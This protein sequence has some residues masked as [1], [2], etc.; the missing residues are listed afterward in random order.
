M[1]APFNYTVQITGQTYSSL[2]AIS[3]TLLGGTPPYTVNWA[4]PNLGID[5]NILLNSSRENL[6]AGTYNIQVN[7]STLPT[8]GTFNIN[9]PISSGV[10]A[11]IL[12]VKNTTCG[13]NNGSVTGTS[14]S[15]YSSTNFYLYTLDNFLISTATTNTSNVVFN[16]LSAGTYYLIAQDLGGNT[17]ATPSFIISQSNSMDFG[18]YV[19]PN[20]SCG[21]N[22][23]G[24]ITVTGL[25]GS[26][27]FTYLW[28]TGQSGS[29]ITGLTSGTY[30]VAVTD[31]LGCTKT[32]EGTVTNI[33]QLGL[34]TIV[35][36][37]PTCFSS[38][39]SFTI[40]VTGGTAPYYFSASTGNISIQYGNSWTL[41][42]LSSGNYG[43]LVTDAALCSFLTNVTL[44]APQGIQQ[45]N[46]TST[47]SVCND[48]DG[49]I[50]VS[51]TGGTSPFTYSIVKPGGGTISVTNSQTSQVFKNLSSGTY[52]VFVTDSGGCTYNEEKTI[53]A[54]NKFVIN[55]QIT[56]TTCNQN[57]GSILITKT[58]GGTEPFT[59]L[60]DNI[61]VVSNT[62]LSAVTFQ[63]VI[64][65][66]HFV[67][68]KDASGCTQTKQIFVAQSVSLNFSLYK[69][70]CG[71]GSQGAITAFIS[72]GTPP[73]SYIWS[74]NVSGNPQSISAT[75][76]SAGTYNLKIID[77]DGCSLT[78]ETTITC[79]RTVSS[80]QTYIMGSEEF[81]SVS[82][83]KYGLLQMLNDGY[84]ELT[85]GNTG[86]ELISAIFNVS[87][88]V[89]PLG[90]SAS[91]VIYTGYTLT[92]VPSDNIYYDAVDSLLSGISGITDVQINPI[93]NQ[94]TITTTKN[95]TT[96][97]GQE[98]MVKLSIDY[99][100]MC[101][102]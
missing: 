71:T 80:Y 36:V 76:L 15:N 49:Q 98:V 39:G 6:Y 87:V 72:S 93:N 68:V 52:S 51:I 2:G 54:T 33:N 3:L 12:S 83:T 64:G 27:P 81:L 21:G 56:G 9:V 74:N 57:N 66:Q 91:S 85:S 29:T 42:G 96:L 90:Y 4:N 25:T 75:G 23:I 1:S 99:D 30:S 43:I 37:Q 26:P 35:P 38:N 84:T 8:N 34:G 18:L 59:Y 50:S 70:S 46:I 89:D 40:V 31:N 101:L 62:T 86:C 95:N 5:S 32:K 73:F 79:D 22:P 63:N 77:N 60:L 94:I 11:S 10:C 55:T 16:Q 65:G 88:E 48:T 7:D 41:S 78:R 58:S 47:N 44:V 67:S 45:V 19:V 17:G 13:S 92:D 100:I 24:K 61:P 69:T 97:T 20:S 28:N 102:T 14:T 82:G 53:F